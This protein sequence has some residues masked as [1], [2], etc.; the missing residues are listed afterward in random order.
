[1]KNIFRLLFTVIAF[2]FV[3]SSY[4]QQ[5]AGYTFEKKISLPGNDGYDYLSIDTVNRHLFVSH[6]NSV[7]VVDLKTEKAIVKIENLKGVHG[8][9]VVNEVNKGFISDGKD[10]SVVVFSLTTF[11]IIKT[12]KLTGNKPDAIMYDPFSKKILAFC[13]D[14]NNACIIDI[15]SLSQTGVIDLGGAP[16]FAVA[17]GKGLIYN[18]LEDKS[19]IAV[20]DAKTM[21]V[22]R[23]LDAAPCGGPTGIALDDLHHRLFTACRV[24]KGMSVIDI[25]TGKV[26]TTVPIGAGVDAVSSDNS[27]GLIVCSNGDGTATIIKQNTPDSYSVIETLTTQPRAKTFA[28]DKFTGKLYFSAA[29]FK[30]GTKIM[31]PDTFAVLVYEK[32]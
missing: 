27:T 31:I 30:P 28:I 20:I 23:T 13:G 24:N 6:G 8:I 7:D 4:G 3:I 1:M 11:K 12:I 19:K 2:P 25:T 29:Q 16:E 18:N 5:V 9:A 21:K 10:N 15:N 26:I 17:D 14:S 32:L 22:I